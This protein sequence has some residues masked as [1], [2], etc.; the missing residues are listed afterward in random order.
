M[1][2]HCRDPTSDIFFVLPLNKVHKT[3]V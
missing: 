2:W 3:N 1:A